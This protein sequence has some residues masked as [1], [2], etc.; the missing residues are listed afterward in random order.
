MKIK[1]ILNIL[2]PQPGIGGLEISDSALKFV[3]IKENKLTFTSL[4]LPAG[5]LEEG[6]IKNKENFKAALSKLHSQITFR[7]KK[8]IYIIVN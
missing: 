7:T 4:N 8:K 6:K 2:N 1:R 3:L 5:T